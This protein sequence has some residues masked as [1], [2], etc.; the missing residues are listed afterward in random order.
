MQALQRLVTQP[1][2]Q[3]HQYPPLS[4]NCNAGQPKA[5]KVLS[6]IEVHCPGHIKHISEAI[7][8]QTI[9]NNSRY[10]RQSWFTCLDLG[11]SLP[12]RCHL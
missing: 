4:S 12:K 5:Q 9:T 1:S 7:W 10:R 3:A 8:H 6:L 11:R 2:P